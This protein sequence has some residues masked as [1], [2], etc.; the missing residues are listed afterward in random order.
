MHWNDAAKK[1]TLGAREG[2]FPGMLAERRFRVVLVD[3]G[4]GVG[5]G[6]TATAEAT[7][8]YKGAQA[9]TSF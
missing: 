6:E 4:H 5:I 7:V 3:K 9:A 8:A 1:L 2:S